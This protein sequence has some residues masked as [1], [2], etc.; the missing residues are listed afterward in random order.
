M[1]FKWSTPSVRSASPEATAATHAPD[2]PATALP[3][4]YGMGTLRLP[5]NN[6]QATRI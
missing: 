6:L 4:A 2:V 1:P 3:G 5:F